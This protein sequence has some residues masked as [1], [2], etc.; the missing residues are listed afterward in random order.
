MRSHSVRV[1][2]LSSRDRGRKELPAT[3]RYVALSRFP[4]DEPTWPDGAWTIEVLFEQPPAEQT[5]TSGTPGV[6]RFL[7]DGAP[8]ERLFEGSL[9]ALYEGPTKVADV[10]VL[11]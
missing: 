6:A 11:D 5:G 3:L 9:F 4:E 1:H 10:T 2:W 7:F 8:H